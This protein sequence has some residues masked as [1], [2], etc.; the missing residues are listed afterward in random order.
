MIQWS[1]F[2]IIE[3][4]RKFPSA[5]S[6][7]TDDTLPNLLDY[8]AENEKHPNIEDCG[9]VDYAAIYHT[10]ADL[11]QGE[12]PPSLND[13]PRLKFN[14]ILTWW[15]LQFFN[16]KSKQEDENE[17]LRKTHFYLFTYQK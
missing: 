11:M 3:K 16:H 8:I 14:L 15:N 2:R 13:A 4:N 10:L 1:N 17:F 5:P 7:S 9:G 6:S 12:A